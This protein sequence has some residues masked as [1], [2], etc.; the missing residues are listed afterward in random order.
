M[1]REQKEHEPPRAHH[2]TRVLVWLLLS[3]GTENV[4]LLL[5]TWEHPSWAL[6]R[7][8]QPQLPAASADPLLVLLPWVQ[9]SQVVCSV[10]GRTAGPMLLGSFVLT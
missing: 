7:D 9:F 2:A 5:P 6:R 8:N 3:W 10:P 1:F 4:V